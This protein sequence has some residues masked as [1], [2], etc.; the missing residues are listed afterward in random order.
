MQERYCWCLVC[1][2]SVKSGEDRSVSD[3]R[4]VQI[5]LVRHASIISGS[6]RGCSAMYLPRD[7]DDDVNRSDDSAAAAAASICRV[8]HL[9]ARRLQGCAGTRA[10]NIDFWSRVSESRTGSFSVVVSVLDSGALSPPLSLFFSASGLS[11]VFF[12]ASGVLSPPPPLFLTS[13]N[14]RWRPCAL[15]SSSL[16]TSSAVFPTTSG[17]RSLSE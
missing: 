15:S 7:R 16:P 4:E 10:S 12:L 8:V 17:D 6:I 1:C 13:C 3:T 11:S 14:R 5:F 2:S 9:S